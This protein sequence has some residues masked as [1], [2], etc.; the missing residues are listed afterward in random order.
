MRKVLTA[1]ALVATIGSVGTAEGAYT[2]RRTV[3]LR[4]DPCAAL[5]SY[6]VPNT[7][8][9]KPPTVPADPTTWDPTSEDPLA[10]YDQLIMATETEENAC[11]KPSPAGSYRD[12]VVTA[13]KYTNMLEF[14]AKPVI[15]WDLFIC[16]KPRTGNNGVV[17][18]SGANDTSDTDCQTGCA[19]RALIPVRAGLKYVLRAYNWSDTDPLVATY[20]FYRR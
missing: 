9:V 5:C 7:P 1:I 14:K 13:P 18:S 19:E 2:Y 17:L 4:A 12:I 16:S 15:D 10:I 11:R 20:T 8:T 3:T 6:W